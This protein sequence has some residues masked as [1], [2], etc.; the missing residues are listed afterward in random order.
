[1]T[2]ELTKKF[3]DYA[4]GIIADV[5]NFDNILSSG[6]DTVQK[7]LET[8][9]DG[10]VNVAGD[11]MTGDL[12]TQN[13]IIQ[14]TYGLR[15]LDVADKYIEIAT[16][17]S[18]LANNITVN[19][20]LIVVSLTLAGKEIDNAFSV[21][22]TAP[23]F[24]DSGAISGNREGLGLQVPVPSALN[25]YT[26][27]FQVTINGLEYGVAFLLAPNTSSGRIVVMGN[28][29]T[30][31]YSQ[32]SGTNL[33]DF[34]FGNSSVSCLLDVSAGNFIMTDQT[35][36]ITMEVGGAGVE[37]DI[38]LDSGSLY[39]KYSYKGMEIN[40]GLT[41][42]GQG[43]VF[44]ERSS[45]LATL[46]FLYDS[47][48]VNARYVF[49]NTLGTEVHQFF[50][51][52]KAKHTGEIEIDGNLN[53]DGSNVGFYGTTPIAQQTGVAVTAAAIHAALVNLGLITA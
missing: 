48:P 10:A 33:G 1:M 29:T 3:I 27:G 47:G 34:W 15:L 24:I 6:D 41:G 39:T 52:G 49:T 26:F 51:S 18:G 12:T 9:D 8:L 32:V 40:S 22:Q 43:V 25:K 50:L 53:H 31:G 16:P 13:V 23:G 46:S 44:F 21:R 30:Y 35:D 38:K 2:L 7:A 5:T 28:G 42:S 4:S 20:P 17:K 14:N 36:I 45:P 11:I 19:I 37:P